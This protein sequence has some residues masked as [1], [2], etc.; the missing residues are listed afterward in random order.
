MLC[1]VPPPLTDDQLSAALD[2]DTDSIVRDHL[3]RCA[4]C[5]ARLEQ[6]RLVERALAGQLHRWDCPSARQ[7]SEYHLGLVDLAQAREIAHHLGQCARCSVEIEQ[8]SRF[9]VADDPPLPQVHQP[10]PS[11]RPRLAELIAHLL[12]PAPA[13]VVRGAGP[14]PIVAEADGVT[15]FLSVQP[16]T[17][18]RINI[19]GQVAADDQERWLG[20]LVEL[21]SSG[22]LQAVTS[23]DAF[24]GWSCGPLPAGVAELRVTREDGT[25]ILLP[26]FELV[27]RG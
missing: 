15:I 18:R 25:V 23:L 5:M 3:G 26:E 19:T 8:F 1:S 22:A 6:A 9:L 14:A 20:A 2:G 12:P 7:L 13:L 27:V 11:P 21:R 10:P 16:T 4:S 24:G 17:D